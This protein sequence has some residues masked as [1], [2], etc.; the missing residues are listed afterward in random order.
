MRA[1][2]GIA[3]AVA[4]AASTAIA[5]LA[6]A[7]AQSFDCSK[8][9]G[10][11]ENVICATPQLGDLD[12]EMASLYYEIRNYLNRRGA[13]ELRDSQRSWLASRDSCGCNANCLVGHYRSRIQ[14]FRN[15]I[16]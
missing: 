10:C 13:R 5:G 15:V 1:L 2:K 4:L 6:P 7:A 11:T 3:V 14:L 8:A 12:S 9:R 16:N